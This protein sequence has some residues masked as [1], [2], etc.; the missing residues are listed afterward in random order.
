MRISLRECAPFIGALIILTGGPALADTI[1]VSAAVWGSA[2]DNGRDGSF[3][4]I[5]FPGDIVMQRIPNGNLVDRGIWEFDLAELPSGS[6][7]SVDLFFDLI[8]TTLERSDFEI[9]SYS[10]DGTVS[11]ADAT[12]GTFLASLS[13]SDSEFTIDVTSLVLAA[14]GDSA[15]YLGFNLRF[16]DDSSNVI[17]QKQFADPD[18]DF[19]QQGSPWLIIETSVVPVPAAVWLFGSVLGLLVCCRRRRV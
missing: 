2:R 17:S 10:G 8:S 16:P 9:Y 14:V 4:S 7:T 1:N 6:I 15:S 3:E 18:S 19:N 12:A 5:S 11:P 13:G